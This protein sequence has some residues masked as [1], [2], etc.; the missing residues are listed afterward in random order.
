MI[1][2]AIRARWGRIVLAN[3]EIRN[4][5]RPSRKP[6]RSQWKSLRIL[7]RRLKRPQWREWKTPQR[8]RNVRFTRM[9]SMAG[10][11]MF[12]RAAGTMRQPDQLFADVLVPQCRPGTDEIL[13]QPNAVLILK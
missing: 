12:H 10:P 3:Q 7:I 6:T 5:C 4:G 2:A 9:R 13:H 8:I 11:M 1:W